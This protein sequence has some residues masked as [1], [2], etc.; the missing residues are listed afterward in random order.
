LACLIPMALMAA[1]GPAKAQTGFHLI[2]ATIDGIHAELRAGRLS[3]GQLVQAYLSRIKAYD[4]AGPT[5]NAVQNVNPEAL[6][7]AF[8]LDGMLQ[9][10]GALAGPL[11]CIPVL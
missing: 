3:C 7:R 8:E 4:Q 9:T 6:K 10:T 11:H 5:L 1:A 2:E